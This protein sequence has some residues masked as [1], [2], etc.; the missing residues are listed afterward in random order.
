M[1]TLHVVATLQHARRVRV[2]PVEVHPEEFKVLV[3]GE[4]L[5][6]T[7]RELQVLTLL[8]VA[9]RRAVR[10]ETIYGTVW[11]KPTPGHHDRSVEA[12]ISRLRKKLAAAAPGWTYIETRQDVGYRLDPQPKGRTH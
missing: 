6:L 4:L 1:D 9:G 12:Y 5:W 3:D 7:R 11:G 10:R 2:G 8:A